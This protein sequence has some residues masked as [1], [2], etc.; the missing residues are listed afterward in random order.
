MI[1]GRH[2]A[3]AL[4]IGI[5]TAI[6]ISLPRSEFIPLITA[7]S[8]SFL[9]YILII[10]KPIDRSLI[11]YW[12][13][14]AILLR[15]I[16][17]FFFPQL[18]DDIYRFIW[19]GELL[20]QGINPFNQLPS[21][22]LNPSDPNIVVEYALFEK[23]NS[24]DYFTVYPPFC[25][26]L[27][28][29][30]ASLFSGKWVAQSLFLKATMLVAEIGSIALIYRILH[31]LKKPL[32]WVLV[33]A[34]NPLVIIELCGNIHF[35]G[36]MI[37]FL[38]AGYYAF[39]IHKPILGGVAFAFGFVTKLIPAIV[40]PFLIKRLS[41]KVLT[42]TVLLGLLFVALAFLPFFNLGFSDHF[43][44]SLNLYFQKFEYNASIYY[45]LRWVG[46]QIYGYNQIQFIG[47]FL[48]LVFVM[49]ILF[50][51]FKEKKPTWHTF[52]S[53][54]VFTLTAYFLLG[55]TVHPWYIT[56]IVAFASL[57]H[58]RYPVIWSFMIFLTY[59]NYRMPE[60][61]EDLVIVFVEYAVVCIFA[62]AE[63]KRI[64][65]SEIQHY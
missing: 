49:I 56:T 36:W 18:S 39:L 21:T 57:T 34:L 1:P 9:V 58:W 45:L 65:Q 64:R 38:L 61:K 27:F 12:V 32:R 23:L 17:L 4:F 20:R 60:F 24:P 51:L 63:L 30:G 53:V 55:T 31:H 5:A 11:K 6:A 44:D 15:V 50:I 43:S 8:A 26:F 41:F 37:F 35:E 3:T 16:T 33:Y 19:D 40:A 22:Y 46:F 29:I 28:W 52:P 48:A 62:F 13:V 59:I 2:L 14:V 47:P 25:Q 54:V 42:K 10:R 7:F